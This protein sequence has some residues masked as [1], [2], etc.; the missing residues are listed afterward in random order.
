M[1]V[2]Y[3]FLVAFSTLFAVVMDTMQGWYS[4]ER[5][6]ERPTSAMKYDS[7]HII[8]FH[9]HKRWS[10]NVSFK[11]EKIHSVILKKHDNDLYLRIIELAIPYEAYGIRWL[12]LLF[13]R[14]FD[15]LT[16][17]HLWDGIFAE[18]RGLEII[19]YVYVAMLKNVREQ[20]LFQEYTQCMGILMHYPRNIEVQEVIQLARHMRQP[21]KVELPESGLFTKP[22]YPVAMGTVIADPE[23]QSPKEKRKLKE[24]IKRGVSNFKQ[25]LKQ[26]FVPKKNSK[27]DARKMSDHNFWQTEPSMSPDGSTSQELSR[28]PHKGRVRPQPASEVDYLKQK[29]ED[30]DTLRKYCGEKMAT[31]LETIQ[32]CVHGM[33]LKVEEEGD[34]FEA[35]AALKQVRDLLLGK[36]MFSGAITELE[37]DDVGVTMVTPSKDPEQQEIDGPQE[38]ISVQSSSNDSRVSSPV[39][40]QSSSTPLTTPHVANDNTITDSVELAEE[41]DEESSSY[42]HGN[43]G[44]ESSMLNSYAVLS[45]S[46]SH[47]LNSVNQDQQQED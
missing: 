34:F 23:N 14:E 12:R 26:D 17:L 22:S 47:P 41:V 40:Q 31:Q 29:M 5:V 6:T 3:V 36:L 28:N 7:N 4:Q 11:L 18:G 8:P 15:F 10:C 33:D 19:D 27:Q 39:V 30:L 38:V 37:R 42:F 2:L 13:S 45:L 46:P 21:D 20:L 9:D 25:D 32:S 24:V 16:S 1:C 35:V 43:Q 44:E